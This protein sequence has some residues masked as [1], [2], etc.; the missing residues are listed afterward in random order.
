[1]KKNCRHY[2]LAIMMVGALVLAAPFSALAGHVDGGD[3]GHNGAER[4]TEDVKATIHNLSSVG[5]QA[6]NIATGGTATTEVCVFCHT[7]HGANLSAPGAAPLWNRSVPT[8]GSYTMYNSPNFE[9]TSNGPVGVSLACLSCHDGS[10]ALDALIN[11]PGSGGFRSDN[12]ADGGNDSIGLIS[13][14][15]GSAFL[16]GSL[17]MNNTQRTDTGTNYGVIQGGAAPFP[18][19]TQNLADDHP[20]SFEFPNGFSGANDDP[21]FT[22]RTVTAV[23]NIGT[24]SSAGLL[25]PAD[26]RD[27]I[28][29]YPPQGAND[30]DTGSPG[31]VECASCHNPHA[32]RPLVLRMPNWSTSLDAANTTQYAS[33]SDDPNQGSAVCLSCHDK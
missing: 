29:M 5:Q 12:L 31:W 15:A 24:I 32:P 13:N 7:P 4:K 30:W 2:A 25:P 10:I 21:Q 8:T 20:I 18:N 6:L 26:K 9:E 3:T 19:L 23:G 17:T 33:F 14:A 1:M 16:D 27:A 22:S 11:A 28:R